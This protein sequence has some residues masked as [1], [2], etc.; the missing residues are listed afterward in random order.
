MF[1]NKDTL[2]EFEAKMAAFMPLPVKMSPSALLGFKRLLTS[3]HGQHKLLES[4]SSVLGRGETRFWS[5]LL[6]LFVW[7]LPKSP[8]LICLDYKMCSIL[9]PY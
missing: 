2:K 4:L 7:F 8:S 9:K 3:Q 1:I 6:M 5:E